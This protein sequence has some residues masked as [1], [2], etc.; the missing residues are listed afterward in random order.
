[1]EK[2]QDPV[3]CFK[4]DHV[5]PIPSVTYNPIRDGA[6]ALSPFS[7]FTRPRLYIANIIALQIVPYVYK[8]EIVNARILRLINAEGRE[9]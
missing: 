2:S 5:V 4:G 9:E 6:T 3:D 8:K 7:H 1:M